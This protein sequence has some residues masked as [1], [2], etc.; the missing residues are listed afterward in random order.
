MVA[1]AL[2]NA[3]NSAAERTLDAWRPDEP[4]AALLAEFVGVAHPLSAQ[5][6]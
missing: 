2:E 6:N 1:V 3:I 5:P 4:P